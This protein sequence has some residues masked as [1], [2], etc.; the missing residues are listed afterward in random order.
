MGPNE[1]APNY[2]YSTSERPSK[3]AV[4]AGQRAFP[5]RSSWAPACAVFGL[6]RA[7]WPR[8]LAGHEGPGHHRTGPLL[9][10]CGGSR[11]GHL[12]DWTSSRTP[13]PSIVPMSGRYLAPPSSTRRTPPEMRRGQGRVTRSASSI[14]IP[15]AIASKLASLLRAERNAVG[16]RSSLLQGLDRKEDEAVWLL[17]C[18]FVRA[19]NRSQGVTY[20]LIRSAVELVRQQGAW[21]VEGWPTAGSDRRPSDGFVGRESVFEDLGFRCVARPNPQRAIMRLE[22]SG[23][24]HPQP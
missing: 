19:E 10:N 8:P 7:P 21:A 11:T 15:E 2:P 9:R 6:V 20:V 3:L 14:P 22:L 16:G 23:T 5:C 4:S 18:L 12:P 1:V 24:H 13:Q 17:A